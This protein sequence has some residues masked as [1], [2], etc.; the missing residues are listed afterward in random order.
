MSK[1]KHNL[2]SSETKD[3]SL[4]IP[5]K[6]RLISREINQIT[7]SNDPHLIIMGPP[8]IGKSSFLQKN[9]ELIK[10]TV[11][12][13]RDSLL[14]DN[15]FQSLEKTEKKKWIIA[16]EYRSE[17][18]NIALEKGYRM[19]FDIIGSNIAQIT[20]VVN[21]CKKQKRKLDII[22]LLPKYKQKL[23]TDLKTISKKDN[24][25]INICLQRNKL[26]KRKVNESDIIKSF[27]KVIY[28][29][30]NLISNHYFEQKKIEDI[31]G[32]ITIIYN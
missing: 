13:N 29:T 31:K 24:F 19:C 15:E 27:P 1:R 26:R 8:G 21:I 10:N 3:Y 23:D 17:L 12:I 14:E 30:I 7:E 9:K 20:E 16:H 2:I 32:K 28:N 22:I 18:K 11:I 5:I 6:K 25:D 4:E